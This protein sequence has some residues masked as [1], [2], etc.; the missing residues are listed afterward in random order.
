MTSFM[1]FMS[2]IWSPSLA[3]I[4]AQLPPPSPLRQ[5]A[6]CR[7]NEMQA[8]CREEGRVQRCR[9]RSQWDAYFL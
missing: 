8:I 6:L 5:P 7:W 4:L 1:N 3:V 9:A 2:D